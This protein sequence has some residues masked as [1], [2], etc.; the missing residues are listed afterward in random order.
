M[1]AEIWE[2]RNDDSIKNR[3]SLLPDST[4]LLYSNDIK[5]DDISTLIPLFQPFFEGHIS[6]EHFKDS[7]FVFYPENDDDNDFISKVKEIVQHTTNHTS[8]PVTIISENKYEIIMMKGD[9]ILTLRSKGKPVSNLKDNL[10][11]FLSKLGE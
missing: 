6:P 1:K 4:Y 8:N 11:N 9:Y 3:I 10:S 7:I 2:E 5:P